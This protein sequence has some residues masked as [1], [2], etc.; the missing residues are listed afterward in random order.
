MGRGKR[1][2]GNGG[3]KV[4]SYQSLLTTAGVRWPWIQGEVEEER[5]AGTQRD[6]TSLNC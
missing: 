2:V 1:S 3:F 5:D 6:R 4:A